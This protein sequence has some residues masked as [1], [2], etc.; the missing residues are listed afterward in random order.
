MK[1]QQSGLNFYEKLF[2]REHK[3]RSILITGASSG[4]GK[5][6]S[7]LFAALGDQVTATARRL[8]RLNDLKAEVERENL[9]GALLPVEA[10]VTDPDAMRRAVALALAEYNRL[11][12]LVANAGIGHRGALV[13]ADWADLETVLR[14]NIDG[15]IHSVRAAVPAMR[16]SGGGYIVLISSILGPVPGPYAAVYS[17]SKA[18]V[19]AL[20]RSL[21]GELRADRIGVSVVHVGQTRTE[22]AEKRLGYPGQVATRWPTLQPGE[23]A[24]A[25]AHALERQPRTLSARTID[26]LFIWAGRRF[27]AIMDR[28]LTRVYR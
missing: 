7:L 26:S 19:D 13:E 1:Q 8:D 14:T 20:G 27:P 6:S 25:I 23:V 11:D 12:V 21:R 2:V 9:P 17:A 22:F 4:I 5:S 3:P 18:A 24:L 28:L 10:D 16:A 15:V